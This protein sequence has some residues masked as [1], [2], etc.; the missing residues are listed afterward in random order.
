MTD[1]FSETGYYAVKTML[2]YPP[3]P[4]PGENVLL[5][6]DSVY[7]EGRDPYY[8]WEINGK[9][10]HEGLFSAGGNKYSWKT[11]ANEGAFPVRVE[12]FPF[13]PSKAVFDNFISPFFNES[14]IF[15]SESN[16]KRSNEFTPESS[17]STLFHFRGEI[18]DS[19]Y[20]PLKGAAG[21]ITGSPA[22]DFRSGIYGYYFKN[23]DSISIPSLSVPFSKQGEMQPFSIKF[24]FLPDYSAAFSEKQGTVPLFTAFSEDGIFSLVSGFSGRGEYYLELV[25]G[26]QRFISRAYDSISAAGNIINLNISVYPDNGS[27]LI[28]WMIN[29]RTVQKDKAPFR[30]ELENTKGSAVIGSSIYPLLIDEAGVFTRTSDGKSSVDPEA[31]RNYNLEKF[32]NDLIFAEGFD[33]SFNVNNI[34][35]SGTPEL[36]GGS[37]ILDPGEMLRVGDQLQLPENVEI[38][39]SG[40]CT[41]IVKDSGGKTAATGDFDNTGESLIFEANPEERYNLYLENRNSNKSCF[42]DDILAARVPSDSGNGLKLEKN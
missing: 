32:G 18:T 20:N 2:S 31:F 27:S 42:A 25:S 11:T 16:R 30:P 28:V 7:P 19:G 12:M 40:N 4:A 34:A 26:G 1:F 15:V 3:D 29:G 38:A 24:R 17:Y 10:V 13:E 36:K 14:I 22:L 6:A 23:N 21:I 8:R 41:L 5:I 37:V 33:N 35:V 9:I 39:V